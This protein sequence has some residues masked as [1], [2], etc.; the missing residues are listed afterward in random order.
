MTHTLHH[1][2]D[3]N[4]DIFLRSIK[5]G[6]IYIK[7]YPYH[8][9]MITL[10][11]L[12]LIFLITTFISKKKSELKSEDYMHQ[13]MNAFEAL[14]NQS[15][16]NVV[17]E[18]IA[19]LIS[20]MRASNP[21][22]S[23]F[24]ALLDVVEGHALMLQ[25]QYQLASQKWYAIVSGEKYSPK[26]LR[27]LANLSF[28]DL[29]EPSQSATFLLSELPNYVVEDSA[30]ALLAFLDAGENFAIA[31]I[32]DTSTAQDD[33]IF[34]SYYIL[35]KNALDFSYNVIKNSYFKEEALV[36]RNILEAAYQTRK[37]RIVIE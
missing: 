27:F 17:M 29:L 16:P 31:M 24:L 14:N 8:T 4:E 37:N 19:G 10:A 33:S 3:E 9:F 25:M 6:I 12:S 34:E 30:L 32:I 2:K 35:G 23:S 36:Y 22:D 11:V 7:K 18:S 1:H 21:D 13:T 20:Q 26:Y 5:K 15:D 28:A